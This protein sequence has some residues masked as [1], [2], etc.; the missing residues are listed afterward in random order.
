MLLPWRGCRS[1]GLQLV[2]EFSQLFNR[3]F[4]GGGVHRFRAGV[5]VVR[6]TVEQG[7]EVAD[8]PD[9]A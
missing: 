9:R 3:E 1:L 5:L 4:G 8:V 2:D 7:H 6:R